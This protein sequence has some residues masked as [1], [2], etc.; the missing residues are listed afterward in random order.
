MGSGMVILEVARTLVL[1]CDLGGTGLGVTEWIS[2][3]IIITKQMSH[4]HLISYSTKK[5]ET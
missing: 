4:Q 2:Y 1:R 5:L 3:I